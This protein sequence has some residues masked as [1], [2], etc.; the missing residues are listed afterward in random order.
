MAWYAVWV[1]HL[2]A[3]EYRG[4]LIAL[5][6][7]T[8]ALFVTGVYFIRRTYWI[9][10]TPTSKI[11]SAHQGYIEIEGVTRLIDAAPLAS[12]LTGTPCVWYWVSVE[13]KE[14]GYQDTGKN[15]WQRVYQHQSDHLIAVSDGSGEC[16]V[17]P[18]GARIHPGV[19][20]QWYGDTEIPSGIAAGGITSRLF[21]DYRYTEK[22]LLPNHAVY[23]L[24]WF[25][26]IAHDPYQ[27]EQEAIKAM[28]REWKTDPEKMRA[29]D[30]NQDGQI[31]EDEWAHARQQAELEARALRVPSNDQEQQTHFMSNDLQGHRPFIISALDQ[32]ALARR[33]R[34]WGFLAWFAS[35]LGFFFLITAYYLRT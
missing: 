31:S 35:L 11:Q 7:F 22:L 28:L 13:H 9:I 33:F 10:N 12:P 2:D 29:F 6:L 3:N 15:L 27:A 24:G 25:K 19:E 5:F 21:G 8:L 1:G 34:R 4:L 23:V 32:A 26:T 18:D 20:R 14:S 17:D 16:L 30:L